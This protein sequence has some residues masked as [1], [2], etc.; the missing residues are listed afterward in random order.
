MV[1]EDATTLYHH[2][3]VKHHP[4]MS[5]ES[6]HKQQHETT[7]QIGRIHRTRRLRCYQS[8]HDLHQDRQSTEHIT[9]VIRKNPSKAITYTI[10]N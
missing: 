2:K 1:P 7:G 9:E 6:R 10:R 5:H 8:Q 4:L 3:E